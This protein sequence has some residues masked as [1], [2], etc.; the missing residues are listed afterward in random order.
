MTE[1]TAPANPIRVPSQEFVR[2]WATSSAAF[3]N[4]QRFE[5]GITRVD[6][7]N[8]G[9][10][11]GASVRVLLEARVHWHRGARRHSDRWRLATVWTRTEQKVW[12]IRSV[13]WSELQHASGTAQFTNIS[14]QLPFRDED[15]PETLFVSYFA[16]GVSLADIDGD[17]NLDVF[18]PRRHGPAMLLRNLGQNRFEDIAAKIGLPPLEGVRS[19]YCFDWDNDGDL[20]LVVLA[21][22]RI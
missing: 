21:H 20:D 16:E 12:K 15:P 17:G 4:L 6:L 2:A 11:D 1:S 22:Q 5:A 10:I 3:G 18:V 13:D 7:E 9:R 8:G 14:G 19:G